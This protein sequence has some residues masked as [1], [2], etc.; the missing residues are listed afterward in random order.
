MEV[1]A[2]NISQLIQAKK[3]QKEAMH[4]AAVYVY[5]PPTI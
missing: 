5:T 1:G 4:T 3:K 2:D